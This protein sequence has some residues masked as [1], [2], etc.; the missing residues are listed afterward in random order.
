[1]HAARALRAAPQSV[2]RT[3]RGVV[4]T[5]DTIGTLFT[6]IPCVL[7]RALGAD[8][9]SAEADIDAGG[10]VDEDSEVEIV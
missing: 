1:M 4:L 5:T 2:D 9:A 10:D 7:L 8:D 6:G 3:D